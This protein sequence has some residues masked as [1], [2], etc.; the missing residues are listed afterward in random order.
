MALEVY[1]NDKRSRPHTTVTVDTSRLGSNSTGTQ[2][3]IVVL[4]SALG[5]IPGEFYKLTSYPQARSIFKGGDLLDFIEVA[6]NP[7]ETASGAGDIYAMRVDTA[8]QA[9]L[10]IGGLI[11]KSAQYGSDAN[12]LAVKLEAGSI[13]NSFKFTALDTATQN[14]EVYDNLGPILTVKYNGSATKA[15]AGIQ[16]KTLALTVDGN[17]IATLDLSNP[18]YE[19]ADKLV[20]AISEIEDFS[21]TLVPY[22]DKAITSSLLD[23]FTAKDVKSSEVTLSGLKGDLIHQTEYSDFISVAKVTESTPDLKT[24][25]GTDSITF[26]ESTEESTDELNT[27]GL[28]TL[29]SGSNG[30]VPSSWQDYLN[31]IR[32]EDMPYA[33]YVVP[34]TPN[35]AIHSEVAS[36]VTDM[37]NSGYPLRAIV[38]GS[39]GESQSKI[40]A[41]KAGLYS[42]RVTLSGF[43]ALVHMGDGR[44]ATFPGYMTTAFI[45][46]IASGL[47]VAEPI[48]YKHLRIVSELKGYSSDQLDQMHAAGVVVVE[49]TRNMATTSFRF[50]SDVTTKNDTNNPVSSEM[51]L[52]EETDFLGNDLREILDENY[53]GTRT[54]AL[55][56]STIKITVSTFLL[57]KK[58]SGDIQDYDPADIAVSLIGDEAKISFVVVPSRGLNKI[59]ASIIY[60]S[61]TITA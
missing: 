26:T 16:D 40:L 56:P 27:F 38:G 14:K 29:Q 20:T 28:R 43:D 17:E 19:T 46:G 34:L 53:I 22:G 35:R 15:T 6:W 49:K 8:T 5:G 59:T 9:Q 52:G 48:T 54:S 41:R 31:K 4:G 13:A 2:K 50:V 23:S 37:T 3:A 12:K 7:S 58:N 60:D 47:P 42:S 32:N 25:V 11:I 61:E 18:L 30:I 45:A 10:V 24:T 55:T 1:P 39:L 33:Y 51:S 21:A 44:T 57:G 36:F